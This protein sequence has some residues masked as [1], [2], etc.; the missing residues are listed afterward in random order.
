MISSP[1]FSSFDIH[2]LIHFFIS[3]LSFSPFSF[4]SF[5]F[6]HYR[7]LHVAFLFYYFL[8]LIHFILLA[9]SSFHFLTPSRGSPLISRY[10]FSSYISLISFCSSI[11][12][13]IFSFSSL[14]SFSS[15]IFSIS[16][17]PSFRM[18]SL[19]SYYFLRRHYFDSFARRLDLL[20]FPFSSSARV[21]SFTLIYLRISMP[22]SLSAF[23]A[24]TRFS[25]SRLIFISYFIFFLSFHFF[26][27]IISRDAAISFIFHHIIA[28]CRCY[29]F[30]M[31]RFFIDINH[32][33]L[34]HLVRYFPLLFFIW[35][36]LLPSS[37]IFDIILQYFAH[38]STSPPD[39]IFFHLRYLILIYTYFL[40]SP[41]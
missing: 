13:F 32:I 10:S 30:I 41:S 11:S 37:Y 19:P 8:P 21:R 24:D 1:I 27:F 34:I 35:H 22:L 2:F 36:F 20:T 40:L 4:I 16:S 3:T 7:D 33:A 6:R 9:D 23:I 18:M 39:I 17:L 38:Y 14:I 25:H 29:S 12:L 15:D 26:I 28:F 5:F 31:L